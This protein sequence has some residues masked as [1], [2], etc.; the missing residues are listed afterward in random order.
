MAFSSK[1]ILFFRSFFPSLLPSFFPSFLICSFLIYLFIYLIITLF[2]CL[3]FVH[4]F[5]FYFNLINIALVLQFVFKLFPELQSYTGTA[6][7]LDL[8]LPRSM[9]T[10]SLNRGHLLNPNS[11]QKST[12]AAKFHE[13]LVTLLQKMRM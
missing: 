8:N 13:S 7:V 3:S 11:P 2:I 5:I 6:M 9:S 12:V 10:Q 1:F 4:Y